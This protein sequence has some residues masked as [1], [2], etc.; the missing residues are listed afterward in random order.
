MMMQSVPFAS[1]DPAQIMDTDVEDASSVA[2]P[3][4]GYRNSSEDQTFVSKTIRFYFAPRDRSKINCV[5]PSEVHS[6][7][8]RIIQTAFG[9]DVKFINNSNRPVTNLET[10][11]SASR[12][13]SY[14]QQFK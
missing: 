8:I 11:S 13:F 7:W 2:T 12:S 6:Q 3:P 14:A 10:G 9:T 1:D 5:K 4:I